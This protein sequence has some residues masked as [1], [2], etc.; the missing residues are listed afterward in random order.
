M[1]AYGTLADALDEHIR[2]GESTALESLRKFVAAFV[3][4]FGS[5]YM[6]EPNEQDTL[7]YLKLE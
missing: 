3:E 4:I 6:R 7:D 1:L 5:E 2:I